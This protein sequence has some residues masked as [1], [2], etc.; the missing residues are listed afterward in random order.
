MFFADPAGAVVGKALTRY[1]PRYNKRLLNTNKTIGGSM[2]VFFATYMSILFQCSFERRL[3]ISLFA[4]LGEALTG[5][6]DNLVLV[7]IVLLGYLTKH[8]NF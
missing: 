5:E 8:L 1:F 6:Y 2:A 4:A 3:L 7:G